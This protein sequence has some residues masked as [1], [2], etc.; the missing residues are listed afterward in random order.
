MGRIMD[1]ADKHGIA[2]LEDVAQANGG[3]FKGKKLG[4]FGDMG[5][6][7]LQTNKNITAGEG[8]LI[9]TNDRE[10]YERAF[11]GHDM[12]FLFKDGVNLN[13]PDHAV[14]WPE[15][16][17]MAEI[18]GAIGN[19]QL[20]KLP[21]IVQHMQSSKKRITDALGS[22]DGVKLRRINDPDGDTGPFI[23]ITLDDAEK[24]TQAADFMK[25]EG[26]HNVWRLADYGY[27]IYSNIHSLVEKTPLSVAGNPWSLEENKD[28]V[29]EYGLGACPQS[30]DLFA[31]SILIPVPSRL[32][33]EQEEAAIEVITKA[34]S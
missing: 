14:M 16:R 33:H 34:V 27:H 11:T 2:V 10:L 1:I 25:A 31:R 5:I 20:G 3:S 30:D 15:G 21:K 19:V 18:L 22:I 8:G 9:L 29:Y 17:R 7:S 13:P 26:L 32:T 24:A 28:S 6:F 4:T 12:G 23:I